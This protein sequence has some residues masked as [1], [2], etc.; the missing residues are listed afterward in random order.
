MLNSDLICNFYSLR[1][2][3]I[4]NSETTETIFYNAMFKKNPSFTINLGYESVP[5]AKVYC[6]KVLCLR[7]CEI[8]IFTG[9]VRISHSVLFDRHSAWNSHANYCDFDI[10]V[11][12]TKINFKSH[13]IVMSYRNHFLS[14]RCRPV[15]LFY[16]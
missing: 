11:F 14:L 15:K 1:L 4:K 6:N 9:T 8:C 2:G 7:F 16:I 10:C 12:C 3:F 5:R 13:S